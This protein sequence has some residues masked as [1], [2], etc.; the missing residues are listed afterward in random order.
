M[1]RW[2]AWK[3]AKADLSSV[4]SSS[5]HL[6]SFRRL[7]MFSSNRCLIIRAGL[8]ATIE[9]AGT[10]FV[11]TAPVP[12]TAPSPTWMPAR[13]VAFAPIQTSF[14]ILV[15]PLVGMLISLSIQL[16]PVP[17]FDSKNIGDVDMCDRLC[18]IN[19]I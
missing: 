2:E 4:S 18:E 12:T 5:H 9:Y 17:L 14:P 10:S 11:T 8:P 3:D 1:V 19:P 15:R 7:I 13:M 6:S 16:V